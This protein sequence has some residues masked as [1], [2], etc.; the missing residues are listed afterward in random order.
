[1]K[2]KTQPSQPP[3]PPPPPEPPTVRDGEGAILVP[4]ADI[5]TISMPGV[6]AIHSITPPTEPAAETLITPDEARALSDAKHADMPRLVADAANKIRDAAGNGL[7]A[8]SMT[9]T[10]SQVD[11]LAPRLKRA[12]YTVNSW[13]TTISISWA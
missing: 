8:V 12:G 6:T 9:L 2:K 7:Y 1:M 10:P 5:P 11:L 13:T 3:V 4:P